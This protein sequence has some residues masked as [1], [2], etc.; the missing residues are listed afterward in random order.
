M[1][2]FR[3]LCIGAPRRRH[4]PAGA[5]ALPAPPPCRRHRPA[6]AHTGV[7]YCD[8]H[9]NRLASVRYGRHG[10]PISMTSAGAGS[11]GNP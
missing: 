10:S 3:A 4:R 6:G 9:K 11:A 5:T 7:V 2:W 1:P 8:R